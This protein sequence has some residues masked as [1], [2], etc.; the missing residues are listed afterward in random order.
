MVRELRQGLLLFLLSKSNLFQDLY[1]SIKET[2][3]GITTIKMFN[4]NNQDENTLIYSNQISN[5]NLTNLE[6]KSRYSLL[7]R[8]KETYKSLFQYLTINTGN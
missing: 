3:F 2:N 1:H 7:K 8:W 4:D 6:K 5:N